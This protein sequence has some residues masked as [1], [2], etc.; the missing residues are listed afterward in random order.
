MIRKVILILPILSSCLHDSSISKSEISYSDLFSV[1]EQK[2]SIN[3]VQEQ[4][5]YTNNRLREIPCEDVSKDN[6]PTKEIKWFYKGCVETKKERL[7]RLALKRP[8]G[9]YKR[10]EAYK[11][12]IEEEAR[13]VSAYENN[14][15]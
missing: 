1:N 3:S 13:R 10:R 8:E 14:K 4:R 7:K 2:H 9:K 5:Y 12:E 11:T 6:L 15:L